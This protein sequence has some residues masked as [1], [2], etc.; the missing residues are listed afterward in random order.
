M[1]SLG[2]FLASHHSAFHTGTTASTTVTPRRHGHSTSTCSDAPM[3]SLYATVKPNM[4]SPEKRTIHHT[5]PVTTAR[6]AHSTKNWTSDAMIVSTRLTTLPH[7][8]TT[9]V[10]RDPSTCI[11]AWDLASSRPDE[12]THDRY[13]ATRLTAHARRSAHAT[14]ANATVR[15]GRSICAYAPRVGLY[16]DVAR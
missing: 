8:D 5:R 10:S 4:K 9:C 12:V 11:P 15:D 16:R 3:P 2:I 14:H 13:H 6:A 7:S 1:S